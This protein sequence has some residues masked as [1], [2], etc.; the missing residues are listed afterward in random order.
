MALLTE[1][2]NA[3]L[4]TILLRINVESLR[5]EAY[6]ECVASA[7]EKLCKTVLSLPISPYLENIEVQEVVAAVCD[8]INIEVA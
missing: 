1:K 2:K 5:A 7:T 4:L 8:A 3:V 6:R